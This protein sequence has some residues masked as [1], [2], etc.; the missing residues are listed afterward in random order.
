MH[1]CAALARFYMT[2]GPNLGK[3]HID[4]Y[5]LGHVLVSHQCPVS[6]NEVNCMV[7]TEN[8]YKD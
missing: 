2:N 8:K 7:K 4:W 5:G 1:A 3:E 6:C